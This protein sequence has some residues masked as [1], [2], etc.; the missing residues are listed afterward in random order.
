MQM[1]KSTKKPFLIFLQTIAVLFITMTSFAQSAVSGK[2]VDSKSGQGVAGVTVSV[3]GTKVATQTNAEG[4]FKLN[5]PAGSN[6]LV[7]SS[8]GFAR[9]EINITGKTFVEVAFVQTNQQLNE[10]VVV[11]YRGSCR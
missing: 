11:G 7:V 4:G 2:V 5:V 8:V 3:E 10:V 9:Q 6:K 1:K